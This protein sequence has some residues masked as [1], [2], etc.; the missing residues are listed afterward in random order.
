VDHRL[1]YMF[2]R[3]Y[4]LGAPERPLTLLDSED[5][6]T[7]VIRLLVVLVI[8]SLPML[9]ASA[10]L[11]LFTLRIVQVKLSDARLEL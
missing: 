3:G 8:L 7:Q 5:L 4:I 10:F 2:V 9:Q 6:Q 1:L 11:A